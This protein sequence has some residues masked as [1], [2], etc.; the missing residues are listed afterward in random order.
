V[1]KDLEKRMLAAWHQVHTVA[2]EQKLPHRI[3]AYCVALEKVA[4]ATR[5]RY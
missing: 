1:N 5:Q 4:E 2:T 3:A